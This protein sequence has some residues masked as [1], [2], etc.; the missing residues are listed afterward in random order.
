MNIKKEDLSYYG[1]NKVIKY[2]KPHW[3]WPPKYKEK[4][5][6]VLSYYKEEEYNKSGYPK[7]VEIFESNFK[8]YIGSK[9]ALSL[10]SGTSALHAAFFAVGISNGDEVLVPSMTFHATAGPIMQVDG[11]PVVC[12]CELDTGNID[13][14]DIETKITKKTK[15]IVI[16]HLCGHPCDMTKI[17]KIAKKNK[18]FLIEDCSHAHGS[19]FNKKKVGTF[20]HIGVFSL[21]NNK[22][23]AAGEGGILV[24]NNKLLF[25]KALLISDFGPRIFSQIKNSKLKKYIETGLGFKHRIHPASAA[26]ANCELKKINFYINK[27]LKVLNSFSN[28]ISNIPGISPP[29]TRKNCTRGAFF[30]YRVFF[31]NKILNN[32]SVDYFV[33]L[34]QAEGMEIR[35][36]SNK[37]LQYLPLFHKNSGAK[38]LKKNFINFRKFSDYDLPNSEYFYNN[39]LSLP[40]F[41]FEDQE[42]I[43]SYIL[44]FKKV[45]G[46]LIK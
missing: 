23:L 27:R 10:N 12:D 37:P 11:V 17:I 38:F 5:N 1:G 40:T 14:Q 33:S 15:A 46:Y 42:L 34:L 32:I 6:S 22:L 8:K 39:T 20:G 16:T 44:A 24:T 35:K 41:T 7:I 31:D 13:P 28:K 25:E 29:V 21:D 19:T 30:G 18:L 9:Y 3:K 2:K 36:A 26:I 45:C 43:D 4:N